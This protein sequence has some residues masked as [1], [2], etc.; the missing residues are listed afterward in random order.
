MRF[1]G[2]TEFSLT[3]VFLCCC[4]HV[5]QS[6]T[7]RSFPSDFPQFSLNPVY[8]CQQGLLTT[9]ATFLQLCGLRLPRPFYQ[10]SPLNAESIKL[11]TCNLQ[12]YVSF[13]QRYL[14]QLLAK[15]SVRQN[16]FKKLWKIACV[17][18][19]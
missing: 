10:A 9:L 16:L 13:G 15:F 17:S 6:K 14:P 11:A 19:G 3:D 1:E 2:K 8:P 5:N 7:C 18:K 4:L 12:L